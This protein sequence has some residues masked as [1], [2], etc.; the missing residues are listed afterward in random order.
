MM[1]HSRAVALSVLAVA[2]LALVVPSASAA[3][4]TSPPEP[5]PCQ[6]DQ[7]LFAIQLSEAHEGGKEWWRGAMYHENTRLTAALAAVPVTA[8]GAVRPGVTYTGTL[9]ATHLANDGTL[10]AGHAVSTAQLQVR[11]IGDDGSRIH[12]HSLGHIAA[13]E[14]PTSDSA[15]VHVHFDRTWC[16]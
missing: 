16:H 6:L 14:R 1:F 12:F 7:G 13:T 4:G 8:T 10:G 5:L 3:A 11:A 9:T 2:L 15:A